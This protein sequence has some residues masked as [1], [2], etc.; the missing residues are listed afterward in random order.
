M[1]NE[2][3]YHAPGAPLDLSEDYIIRATALK[4]HVRAFAIKT[5]NAV[6]K[7]SEI[8]GT[9]SVVTA[10]LG[11][12]ITGSLLLAENMK[13]END[14]QTTTIKC[15]G[16]I[17]GMTC[18]CDSKGNARAYPINSVVESTYLRPGKLNVGEAVG[19]GMLTIVRDIGL[20]EPY[21]GSIELVTGE[22]A[23]DFTYYLAKSE[24][25]PSIVSL[26]VQIDNTGVTHA[27]GMMIQLLPGATEEDI[28]YLEKRVNGGFPEITFL[29]SEGLSPEK[30]VDMFLGDPEICYLS[31]EKV[32]FNCNCSAEK[33]SRGLATLGKA[34][35]K[36]LANDSNGIDIE[37]HFCNSKYHFTSE[38]VIKI[39]ENNG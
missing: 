17:K 22:I 31:G 7:A 28:D 16:P 2:S 27:G 37:C 18:V 6:K 14:S 12:F 34:E 9:S 10:A 11:R 3:F 35:L 21:V 15:D 26:G 32:G 30:I 5:T 24:Q 25:T 19:N 36:E 8:H 1:I 20:R 23:E 13:G 4:G 33:M 39:I 29:M 38:D